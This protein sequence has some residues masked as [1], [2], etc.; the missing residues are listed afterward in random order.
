MV[1]VFSYLLHVFVPFCV[2]AWP[3][4]AGILAIAR[5]MPGLPGFE[6]MWQWTPKLYF[7][8]AREGL[9]ECMLD[10]QQAWEG[11]LF[12]EDRPGRQERESRATAMR[13]IQNGLPL[14]LSLFAGV[15]GTC[16]SFVVCHHSWPSLLSICFNQAHN[17]TCLIMAG[18]GAA[19]LAGLVHIQ[20]IMIRCSRNLSHWACRR[21]ATN[22]GMIFCAMACMPTALHFSV[23]HVGV[24]WP[25]VLNNLL[26]CMGTSRLRSEVNCVRSHLMLMWEP[27]YPPRNSLQR[28]LEE[29]GQR[30][31]RLSFSMTGYKVAGNWLAAIFAATSLEGFS[32]VWLVWTPF[33]A[34]KF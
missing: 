6:N 34:Q 15:T 27:R 3:S 22:C 4:C 12:G 19:A 11:F 5:S 14:A 32:Y 8:H 13:H 18:W 21:M 26:F 16:I 33:I 25:L 17:S 28:I 2:D 7:P 29:M 1:M 20:L 24:S 10:L 31:D 9:Q 30:V 23:W